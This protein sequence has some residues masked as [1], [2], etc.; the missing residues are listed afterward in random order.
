MKWNGWLYRWQD[1]FKRKHRVCVENHPSDS[2]YTW[3][4]VHW[5]ALLPGHRGSQRSVNRLEKVWGCTS[6]WARGRSADKT[7]EFGS[8]APL[9][10]QEGEAPRAAHSTSPPAFPT[11]QKHWLE[12]CWGRRVASHLCYR[13]LRRSGLGFGPEEW[14]QRTSPSPGMKYGKLAE[15]KLNKGLNFKALFKTLQCIKPIRLFHFY[16]L[17]YYFISHRFKIALLEIFW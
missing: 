7:S 1:D 13:C 17:F 10:E 2:L 3:Q 14:C 6:V 9:V 12:G 5:P 11:S 4:C 8:T 16:Y 15:W